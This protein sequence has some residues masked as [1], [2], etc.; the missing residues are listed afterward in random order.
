MDMTL[1]SDFWKSQLQIYNLEYQLSLPT[2]R[3]RSS[4]DQRSGFAS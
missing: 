4:T 2:D 3:Q 1:S